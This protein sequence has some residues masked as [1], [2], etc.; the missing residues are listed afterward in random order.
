MI[1]VS[2]IE[3]TKNIT[4]A[5]TDVRTVIDHKPASQLQRSPE[6]KISV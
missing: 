6:L 2:W 4:V 5:I 1:D 3:N